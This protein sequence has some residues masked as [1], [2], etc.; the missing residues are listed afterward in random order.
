M[1]DDSVVFG[2]TNYIDVE[3]IRHITYQRY[4]QQTSVNHDLIFFKDYKTAN[5]LE[6]IQRVVKNMFHFPN[7]INLKE[8]TTTF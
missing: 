8:K 7:K 2:F 6:T 3:S 4:Q 1:N 5:D